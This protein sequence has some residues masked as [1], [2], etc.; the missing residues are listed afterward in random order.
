MDTANET[1][2]SRKTSWFGTIGLF[3]GFI[4]LALAVFGPQIVEHVAP[5]PPRKEI[6]E[7]L[8]DTAVKIKE[9]LLHKST[10]APAPI[11]PQWHAPT[12]AGQLAMG[13]LVFAFVGI[14]LGCTS[15][16]RQEDRRFSGV[17]VGVAVA[18]LAWQQIIIAVAVVIVFLIL[19]SIF[20]SFISI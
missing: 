11:Q 17:A 8:A 14:A 10:P 12:L 7:V 4:G 19:I 16:L 2:T 18:A 15:W 20:S 1:S 13:S 9:R 6:S 3:A 5:R